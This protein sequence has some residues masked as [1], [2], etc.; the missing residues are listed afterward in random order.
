MVRGLFLGGFWFAEEGA[1]GED[2]E[3]A[4]EALLADFGRLGGEPAEELH[5]TGW[6]EAVEFFFEAR[7]GFQGGFEFGRYGQVAR[8]E[9]DFERDAD[10]FADVGAG[11]FAEGGVY[12]EAIASG[13][14]GDEG[15]AGAA[16]I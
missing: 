16:I 9:I 11:D 1:L 14:G 10:D 12:L 3:G 15:G 2:F 6:G 13:A 7:T 4:G 5:A 8:C